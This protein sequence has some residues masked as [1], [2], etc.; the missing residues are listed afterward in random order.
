MKSRRLTDLLLYGFMDFLMASLAWA[1]FFAYRKFS[2][3]E[4]FS[5]DAILDRN[6]FI[7]IILIPVGW[8][9]LYSIF[10]EYQD[11]YRKSRIRTLTGT[12]WLSLLGV[13]FLF[14]TLILDDVVT[15]YNDYIQSFVV[16]FL[17]HFFLTAFSRA[18]LLTRASNR[19]ARGLI[20]FPTLI[21]GANDRALSLYQEMIGL[22]KSLGYA[23]VGFVNA[24]ED[25]QPTELAKHI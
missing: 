1:A 23:F 15:D 16:L 10:D 17:L 25:E 4:I 11:L 6:F 24:N 14:F 19:L 12:F 9:L 7:G 22:R 5:W 2:E 13:L 8:I 21:V 18:V 20:T 3:N